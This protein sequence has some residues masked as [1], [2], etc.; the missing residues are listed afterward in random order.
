MKEKFYCVGCK[1]HYELSVHTAQ[2]QPSKGGSFRHSLISEC[3]KG[4]RVNKLCKKEVYETYETSISD[5]ET[6]ESPYVGSKALSGISLTTDQ[7]TETIGSG[8]FDKASLNSSGHQNVFANAEEEG[9]IHVT[10]KIQDADYATF[11]HTTLAPSGLS[12]DELVYYAFGR[13]EA[14]EDNEWFYIPS[15]WEGVGDHYLAK[16]MSKSDVIINDAEEDVTNCSWCKKPSVKVR[17][18]EYGGGGSICPNCHHSY[19]KLGYNPHKPP[20]PFKKRAESVMD[21]KSK[22]PATVYG[23]PVYGVLVNDD[24]WVKYMDNGFH[25]GE[26]GSYDESIQ[27]SVDFLNRPGAKYDGTNVKFIRFDDGVIFSDMQ[28]SWASEEG[29]APVQDPMEFGEMA[30]WTPL[31]GTPSLRKRKRAE[32]MT[33]GVNLEALEPTP[34]EP[35]S[36]ESM[37]PADSLMPEGSGHVI[38][39]QS[40]SH[41]Y[42]PFHAEG[43]KYPCDSCNKMVSRSDL[44]VMMGSY[45]EDYQVCQDCLTYDAET[46][47]HDA[48]SF[49]AYPELKDH[50][51][52]IMP[53]K[54]YDIVELDDGDFEMKVASRNMD[55][56][57]ATVSE[58][59]IKEKSDSD[60]A[61]GKSKTTVAVAAAG[62]ALMGAW[63]WNKRK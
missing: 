34:D 45:D 15:D 33:V 44:K 8:D 32:G 50:L 42:T 1:Q 56:V 22:A 20:H 28:F 30:N 17:E 7:L 14:S 48:E 2:R 12:D 4:H 59:Q 19:R 39:S 3:P 43:Q 16:V 51:V 27:A 57:I 26:D 23:K 41:N 10:F 46:E 54:V 11:Y 36:G 63:L 37:V 53:N 29:S 61:F 58:Y 21:L 31:D 40:T 47:V 62:V 18:V 52:S 5:A 60:F 55:E 24:G 13:N 6:F 38:G 9:N 35:E 25:I 49:I